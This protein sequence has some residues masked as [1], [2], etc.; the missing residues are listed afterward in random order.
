[1]QRSVRAIRVRYFLR[2]IFSIILR[3]QPIVFTARLPSG[4]DVVIQCAISPQPEPFVDGR[5]KVRGQSLSPPEVSM[6]DVYVAVRLQLK[7]RLGVSL[8]L[9]SSNP[10]GSLSTRQLNCQRLNSARRLHG[11]LIYA[12]MHS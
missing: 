6:H 10:D 1:M 8:A 11:T 9:Y 2:D 3:R 5:G 12:I 7:I 4:M